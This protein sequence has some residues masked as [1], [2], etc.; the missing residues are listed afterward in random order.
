M[1]RENAI[2]ELKCFSGTTNLKFTANFWE[3]LNT[4]I[5]A[6]EQETVSKEVYDHEY[7]LRKEFEIKEIKYIKEIDHLRRYISKL[8]T[9]IAEQEQKIGHWKY[10]KCDMCGASRPPLFDNYCPHCGAYMKSG[11]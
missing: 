11:E 2:K 3:A 10:N 6:L 9:Q 7:F 8:E 5:K 1:T 4:A